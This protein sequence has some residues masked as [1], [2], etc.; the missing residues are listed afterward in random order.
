MS[1]NHDPQPVVMVLISVNDLPPPPGMHP[2]LKQAGDTFRP[3]LNRAGWKHVLYQI[4]DGPTHFEILT[5]KDEG[6][7]R[8]EDTGAAGDH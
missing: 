7:W 2:A 4:T 1:D 8:R 6:H 3:V 5:A